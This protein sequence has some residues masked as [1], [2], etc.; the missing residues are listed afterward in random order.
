MANITARETAYQIIR[1]RIITL[2]L[3]PG[4]ILNDRE[5]AEELGMSRTPVR[6]AL[7]LLNAVNLVMVKPQSGTFVAPIN[8]DQAE[9]EQFFRFALEKEVIRRAYDILSAADKNRYEENL[10]LY[11]FYQKSQVPGREGKL[12]D[13]DNDFHRIAFII[14]NKEAYFSRM[15]SSL[16]HIERLRMLSLLA[17]QKDSVYDDHSNIAQALFHRDLRTAEY[18]LE[19]H[20]NR[21]RTHLKWTQHVYPQFFSTDSN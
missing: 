19:E 14:T 12:L 13:L 20:L 7:I 10:Q 4:A 9:N 17:I 18:W 8:L 16:H 2:D 15:L 21:Y 6:E 3:K 5:L 1:N 11:Q